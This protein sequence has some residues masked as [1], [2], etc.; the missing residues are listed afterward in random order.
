MGL[1]I[2]PPLHHFLPPAP[3]PLKK[4]VR[5][6]EKP[7]QTVPAKSCSE[8]V[9]QKF[10]IEGQ[11]IRSPRR[12]WSPEPGGVRSRTGVAAIIYSDQ[13]GTLQYMHW[14]VQAWLPLVAPYQQR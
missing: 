8:Q 11:L 14:Q 12:R 5:P 2:C 3:V 13:E 10:A 7:F 9:L 6:P 1:I 4:F